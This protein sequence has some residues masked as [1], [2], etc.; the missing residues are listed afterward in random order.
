MFQHEIKEQ[1][2]NNRVSSVEMHIQT[3]IRNLESVKFGY[4]KKNVMVFLLFF[5]YPRVM[6][7]FFFFFLLVWI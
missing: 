1:E 2:K 4:Y 6:T 3:H 7:S 5:L